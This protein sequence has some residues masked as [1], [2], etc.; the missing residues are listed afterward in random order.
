MRLLPALPLAALLASFAVAPGAAQAAD[1]GFYLGGA[2]G[3]ANVNL[4]DDEDVN[5]DF[6]EEDL[7]WK[8]VAG[9]RPL[10]LIGVEIA[11]V[12]FGT[13]NTNIGPVRVDADTQALA[14]F[15]MLYLP[16]PIV[17]VYAKAGL[18]RI[19]SDLR[20]SGGLRLDRSETEF[21]WGVGAG[22][23]FGNWA[24]RAEYERFKVGD[25]DPDFISI[26]L[27]WTFL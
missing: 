15:G 13:P 27:T 5:F 10:D 23:G 9:V 17:D 1:N 21:A 8:V 14:G 19:E 11:Y 6:D 20:A 18:A 12:D 24:I 3:Q 22:I 26:G 4:D 16:L 2:V 7:G 25:T